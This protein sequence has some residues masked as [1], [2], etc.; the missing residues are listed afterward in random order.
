MRE[1]HRGMLRIC[2][3]YP[4]MR[5]CHTG[6]RHTGWRRPL[7]CLK[8][9]VIVRKRATNYRALLQK[10]TYEDKASY[11]STP[12]CTCMR[13]SHAIGGARQELHTF[14]TRFSHVSGVWETSEWNPWMHTDDVVLSVLLI[15]SLL[16]VRRSLN[17]WYGALDPYIYMIYTC[18]SYIH[19]HHLYMYIIYTYTSLVCAIYE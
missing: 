6:M 7:R 16:S 19:I 3:T 15:I 11:E 14:L 17:I 9:Q 1:C 8:L 2:I 10:M 12:P 4:C 13:T 5:E 18:T